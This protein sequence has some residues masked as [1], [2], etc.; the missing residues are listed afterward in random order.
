MPS[1]AKFDARRSRA[2]RPLPLWVDAFR[3]DTGH[4]EAD[5]IGAYMN[6]LMC[7]WS[8]RSLSLPDDPRRLARAAGVSVR[9]WNSRMS[10]VIMPFLVPCETGLTQRRLAL[11]ATYV[12]RHVT[13]QHNRRVGV[14]ASKRLKTKSAGITVDSTGVEPGSDLPN[15][16]TTQHI[17]REEAKASLSS[18]P[19]NDDQVQEAVRLFKEAAVK[20][21][22][23]VP[24]ILSRT[25]RA[26]LVSR[27][28]ECGGIEGWK[29]AL[30]KA[31]ASDHCCGQNKRGWVLSFDFITKQSSFA[32]LMEGNYDNRFD[33]T[34]RE[35][36]G[37]RSRSSDQRNEALERSLRIAG[38]RGA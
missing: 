11:E 3:R 21:N 10:G 31:Q 7:I 36:A 25:R 15:N 14:K 32:K 20:S 19:Q 34:G 28:R 33:R 38:V 30:E 13:D 27:L 9:L 4:L 16:P 8:S 35:K 5:E 22:W 12:E 17:E 2:K 18:A 26:A 23:P 6:I 37:R 1:K 24:R 29:I